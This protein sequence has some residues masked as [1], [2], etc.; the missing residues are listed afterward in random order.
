MKK[1]ISLLL[2]V[3]LI[4][5]IFV[6]CTEISKSSSTDSVVNT[7][8]IEPIKNPE[9]VIIG[10]WECYLDDNYDNEPSIVLTFYQDGVV[11]FNDTYTADYTFKDGVLM[12]SNND[13]DINMVYVYTFEDNNKLYLVDIFDEDAQEYKFIRKD[14]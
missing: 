10:Q 8:T 7:I 13:L 9:D 2:V 12:W 5:G 3:S 4:I 14:I 6:G 11:D 1:P